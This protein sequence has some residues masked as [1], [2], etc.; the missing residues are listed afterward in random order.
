MTFCNV[1][2]PIRTRTGPQRP[3][4]ADENTI[5][6]HLRQPSG[7]AIAPGSRLAGGIGK[8]G[9]QRPALGEVTTVAVNRKVRLFH[10]SR[11]MQLGLVTCVERTSPTNLMAKT[12]I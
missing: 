10:R 6:K 7:I 1:Q 11:S 8:A 2:L 9:P 3:K 12:K 5:N 4:N